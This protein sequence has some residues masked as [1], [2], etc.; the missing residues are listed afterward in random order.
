MYIIYNLSLHIIIHAYIIYLSLHD[1][2]I[3]SLH[4]QVFFEIEFSKNYA[5]LVAKSLFI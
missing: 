1:I 5:K 2:D 3:Y 4:P